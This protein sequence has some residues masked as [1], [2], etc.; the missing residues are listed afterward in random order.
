MSNSKQL[1]LKATRAADGRARIVASIDD[2]VIAADVVDLWSDADRDRF[3][4]VIH[5]KVPALPMLSIQR[6]LLKIDREKL[7]SVP[8]ANDPWPELVT[9]E[10]PSVPTFPVD[11]LPDPLRSWAVATADAV[12]V[13]T[14]LPALLSL[15]VCAGAS[16]R[17]VEVIAGAVLDRRSHSL[18]QMSW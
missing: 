13:P 10:R 14:D 1:R 9:I 4:S 11:V 5:S 18:G 15:A 8:G 17:R 16:A 2:E 3:S 7:P 12:Q 6:E